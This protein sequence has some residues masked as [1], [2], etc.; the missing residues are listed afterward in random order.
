[1]NN[2]KE[3][4]IRSVLSFE[5]FYIKQ[6]EKIDF[7]QPCHPDWYMLGANSSQYPNS[8]STLESPKQLYERLYPIA[9]CGS[10]QIEMEILTEDTVGE[11][12][13]YEETPHPDGYVENYYSKAVT[14][15]KD[16]FKPSTLWEK[17]RE[18]RLLKT[19]QILARVETASALKPRN[20]GNQQVLVLPA[21]GYTRSL[22][23]LQCLIELEAKLGKKVSEQF[24]VIAA[25]GDSS[26]IAAY[27][28]LGLNLNDLK[29]W[30]VH[31]WANAYRVGFLDSAI[32]RLDNINPFSKP[33]YGYSVKKAKKIL[34]DL[35]SGGLDRLQKKFYDM[36]T[37]VYL[38]AVYSK[39][40]ESFA[41]TKVTSE[42][43]PIVDALMD[44]ALDPFHF[45]VVQTIK[46]KGIPLPIKDVEL[47]V[48]QEN[49]NVIITKIDVPYLHIDHGDL[50]HATAKDLAPA[51]RDLSDFEK[52]LST[53]AHAQNFDVKRAKYECNEIDRSIPKNSTRLSAINAAIEAGKSIS[54]HLLG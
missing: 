52:K 26:I 9:T 43:L 11:M 18:N 22:S 15:Y 24:N 54:P 2:Q 31:H 39:Y 7:N 1:M 42:Q 32:R 23:I 19:N 4:Q 48:M 27:A 29:D 46:N 8:D 17:A 28:A 51:I 34:R 36:E 33:K 5:E 16:L 41:Y 12:I 14:I 35:F 47:R 49:K 40:K 3:N 21:V 25:T 10:K 45:D 44:I 50:N 30:W 6:Q 37:E 38:P 53:E 13:E 20:L